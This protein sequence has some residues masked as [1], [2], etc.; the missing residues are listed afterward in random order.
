MKIEWPTFYTCVCKMDLLLSTTNV[1]SISKSRHNILDL[2]FWFY[3]QMLPFCGEHSI[4]ANFINL[5]S[6]AALDAELRLLGH[7][8]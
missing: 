1:C 7:G 8:G 5:K 3:S 4:A 2:G 6:S